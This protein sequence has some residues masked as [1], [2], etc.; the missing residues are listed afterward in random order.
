MRPG[1]REGTSSRAPSSLRTMPDPELVRAP[2]RSAPLGSRSNDFVLREHRDAGDGLP[3][4]GI[5]LHRHRSE[6]EAWYI[7]EGA[8]RFRYGDREFEAS[9]GTGVLLP[10][11]TP[12][13]FWN[14]GP[15]A[16]RYLMIVGPKTEGL[17][18]AL[19]GPEPIDAAKLRDVYESFDAELLE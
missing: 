13:T 6:D 7:L 18:E 5:P 15:A 1:R 4:H 10:R 12:H 2:L 8:L 19:H 16:V 17:L 11:G 9:D 3:R 14:P